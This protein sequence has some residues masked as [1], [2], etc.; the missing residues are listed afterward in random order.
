MRLSQEKGE[1]TGHLGA[2]NGEGRSVAEVLTHHRHPPAPEG[3]LGGGG[4]AGVAGAHHSDG[5]L[6]YHVDS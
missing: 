1:L 6:P 3:E 5:P 4:E 2:H